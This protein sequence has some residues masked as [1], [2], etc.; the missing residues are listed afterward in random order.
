IKYDS[1]AGKPLNQSHAEMSGVE[2]EVFNDYPG[3]H[4]RTSYA[5]TRAIG[6][7][8]D[9]SSHKAL[10][11]TPKHTAAKEVVC[12]FPNRWSVRNTLRY[13]HK[14]YQNDGEQG[15]KLPSFTLWNMSLTKKV[16]SSEFMVGVDNITD[17]HYAEAISTVYDVN[18]NAVS[19]PIPQTGRTYRVGVTMRFVD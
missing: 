7:S 16:L 8:G 4:A 15:I 1:L 14:Q 17:K 19:N 18:Y 2:L 12:Q 3:V 9:N 6:T 10:S 13:V 11:L 5:Y